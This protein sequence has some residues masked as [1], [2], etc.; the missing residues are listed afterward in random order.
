LT[1]LGVLDLLC[2][3]FYPTITWTSFVIAGMALAR[4]DL[5]AAAVEWRLAALGAQVAGGSS[6]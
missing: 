5:P 3:G 6:S 4:F 1:C 2:T